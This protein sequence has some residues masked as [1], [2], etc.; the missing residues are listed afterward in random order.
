MGGQRSAEPSASVKPEL[1]RVRMLLSDG[2]I[3]KVAAVN[4]GET[5][6][7]EV[8]GAGARLKES[9]GRVGRVVMSRD[10]IQKD[11]GNRATG[12]AGSRE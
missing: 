11:E 7:P 3:N 5:R 1:V 6:F 9:K 10:N 12:R 2:L 8:V 4:L